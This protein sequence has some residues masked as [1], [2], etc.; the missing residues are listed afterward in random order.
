MRCRACA[1]ADGRRPRARDEARGSSARRAAR[2][3]RGRGRAP[4][5]SRRAFADALEAQRPQR[6][7]RPRRCFG[8]RGPEVDR[9]SRAADALRAERNGDEV[10]YVVCR[11]INY[12]NVCYFRCGFCA[13]SKGKLGREPARARLPARPSTRSLR[14]CARG[15]GPRRAPRSACRAASIPASPASWYIELVE[16]IRAELPDLH[17]HAFSPLEVWQGADTAGHAA[18]RLPRAPARRR[19]RLAAGHRGRDPRRRGA[20]HALPRQG[21]TRAVARG[22]AHGARLG[23]PHDVDDHVRPYRAARAPGPPPARAARPGARDRRLHRVRAA[24]VRARGGADRA[25][26]PARRGPDVPRG[27]RAAR[28][29][30]PAARPAHHEHPGLVGEAR[31]GGRRARCS[32][33]ASTTSAARS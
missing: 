31:P 16:A 27:G 26:G 21:A 20:P 3:R 19:A 24:A 2:R 22:D 17:I 18:A 13:F 1:A 23:H 28:G 5:A 4:A 11:N 25:E 7:R 32:A 15:V 33:P 6:R 30:A 10:T 8:A 14:R 9:W 12:T 29:R